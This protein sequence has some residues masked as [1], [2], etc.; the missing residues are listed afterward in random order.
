[1]T[2]RYKVELEVEISDEFHATEEE[3][4]EWIRCE[5]GVGCQISDTNPLMPLELQ[6]KSGT[7]LIYRK[8]GKPIPKLG[9]VIVQKGAS[10]AD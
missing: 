10:D 8:M 7:V 5:I 6:P 3:I 2:R 1:M 4:E 9:R